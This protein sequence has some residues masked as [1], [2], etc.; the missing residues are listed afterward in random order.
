MRLTART[1]ALSRVLKVG[2]LMAALIALPAPSAA[3]QDAPQ[4]SLVPPAQSQPLGLSR[5]QFGAMVRDYLLEHPEVLVEAIEVLQAREEQAQADQSRNAIQA[6]AQRLYDNP[7]TPIVGNPDGDITLVEFSDYNCPYCRRFVD[8]LFEV[9]EGDGNIRVVMME[10]PILHETSRLAS[11]AALAAGQQGE[12]E[13]MHRALLGHSGGF[14]QAQ[15]ETMAT[16][17]G[18]DVEQLRQDMND[19]MLAIHLADV[20]SLAQQIGITGTPSIIVG[21]QLIPGAIDA[22]QLRGLIAEERAQQQDG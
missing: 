3:A 18:L 7:M 4:Q 21:D 11:L 14:D 20:Q 10:F 17:L 8:T 9:V 6:N 12:Y 15:I 16:E 1:A 22:A 19:P 13:A 2:G 5:D